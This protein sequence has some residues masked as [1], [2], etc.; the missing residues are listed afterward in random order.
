MK[1]GNFPVIKLV[2]LGEKSVGK[3]CLFD[4]LITGDMSETTQTTIGLAF[5]VKQFEVDDQTYSIS[6]IDT[7]GAEKFDSLTTFYTRGAN[8]AVI[9]CD[10]TDRTSF[11]KA[12]K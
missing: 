11:L 6:I 4:R 12:K 8:C 2:L 5:G 3:T 10:L 7:A 9:C 1:N